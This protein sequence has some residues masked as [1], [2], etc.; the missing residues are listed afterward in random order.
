MSWEQLTGQLRGLG[1]T[2]TGEQLT[3]GIFRRLACEAGLIPMV[4]G[5][6]GQVLD[7]VVPRRRHQHD[8]LYLL[9]PRHPPPRFAG[10]APIRVH[11]R[12]LTPTRRA[13]NTIHWEP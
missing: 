3:P 6:A 2:L 12:D 5:S 1:S 8:N 13:D 4:L 7:L 10:G 11:D 9:C